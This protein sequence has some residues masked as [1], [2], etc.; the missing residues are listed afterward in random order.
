MNPAEVQNKTLNIA[1]FFAFIFL[2]ITRHVDFFINP[3]FWAEEATQYFFDA[4]SNGISAI[5]TAHKG[6]YSLTPSIAAYFSTKAPLENAPLITTL[7]AFVVQAIPYYLVLI[8]KSEFLNT[9]LKKLLVSMIILFVGNTPEIWLNSITSQFH[10]IIIVFL[11]LIENKSVLSKAKKTLFYMLTLFAG[12]SGIPANLLAPMFLY[13][14]FQ[15]KEKIN[16]HLLGIFFLTSITHIIFLLYA[17]RIHNI[18]SNISYQ[19]LGNILI[20]LFQYPIFYSV[21][22]NIDTVLTIP[23]LYIIIKHISQVK[24]F[25][26]FFGSA[27]FL[28]I[29]MIL[30]SWGMHGGQRYTYASSVIFVLGLLSAMFDTS[31]SKITRFILLIYICIALYNGAKHHQLIDGRFYSKKWSTWHHQAIL[32]KD[33]SID[34]IILCPPSWSI[35]LPRK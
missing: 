16:L 5:W 34:K 26:I 4:Y 11:L 30:T 31:F 15:T 13:R 28:G 18:Q 12:L 23:L 9:S 3:R 14:Y 8:S 2:V 17:D 19:V 1:I 27:V 10:F 29:F 7:F 22:I 33:K 25:E 21:K 35:Q 24:Y 6:Y 20:N 32:F